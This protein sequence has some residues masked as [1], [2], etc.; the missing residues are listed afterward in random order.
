MAGAMTAAPVQSILCVLWA[1]TARTAAFATLFPAFA[2]LASRSA[3]VSCPHSLLRH[4]RHRQARRAHAGPDDTFDFRYIYSKYSS[5]GS[6]WT[7]GAI[8]AQSMRQLP[9]GLTSPDW[10]HNAIIWHRTIPVLHPTGAT[11]YTT[12][13]A[14]GRALAC[15]SISTTSS[16]VQSSSHLT[17]MAPFGI[18][19]I[20]P[21]GTCMLRPQ[22]DQ[23]ASASR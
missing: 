16:D 14:L 18:C 1:L 12:G 15:A 11:R 4:R 22:E 17:P 9:T 8:Q 21:T 3:N 5:F 6:G 19:F 23:R 2:H 10:L 7:N 13:Y 20:A